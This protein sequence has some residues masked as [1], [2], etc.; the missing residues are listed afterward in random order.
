M[1]IAQEKYE[2]AWDIL[3]DNAGDSEDTL[4]NNMVAAGRLGKGPEVM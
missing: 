4:I 3:Q 1:L 2:E